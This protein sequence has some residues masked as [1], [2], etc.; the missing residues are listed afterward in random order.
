MTHEPEMRVLLGVLHTTPLL[1]SVI[2]AELQAARL[3]LEP[4][5][6]VDEGLLRLAVKSGTTEELLER[7]A[8][9]CGF[10]VDS[11][12]TAILVSCSSL[13]PAV[14]LLRPQVSYRIFRIDEPMAKEAIAL[15]RRIGVVATIASALRPMVE[16]LETT[17]AVTGASVKV[18]ASL[19]EGAFESMRQGRLEEHDRQ[20][21]TAIADLAGLV[22]AIVLAQASMRRVLEDGGLP[23]VDDV[24]VLSSLTSGVR[25]LA[26]FV[27]EL[28]GSRH[29]AR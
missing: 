8:A 20:V 25:Q 21:Q 10:L 11:G 2:G 22:D 7:V 3:P 27:E 12:A 19:C 28:A 15:G 16:L 5:H 9:Q 26:P 24:P 1:C 14:A 23:V 13:G 4:V 18:T 17:A 29:L 6:L